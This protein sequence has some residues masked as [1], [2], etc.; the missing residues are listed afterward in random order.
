MENTLFICHRINK[1][2]ELSNVKIDQG[3]ELDLRDNDK[4][5][6][7]SHDPFNTG[8]DFEQIL[9][10]YNKNLII[11]N[12]KSERIEYKILELLQKYN[13]Q[14]YFFLDSSFPMIYQLNKIGEKNIAV[15]FSEFESIESVEAVKDMVKWVWVDCF[16]HFPLTREIYN[17]IKK[18]NLKICLVSPELQG[19]NIEMIYE[20]KKIIKE[21]NFHIDAICTK[22]YS[23]ELWKVH[24]P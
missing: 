23:V 13:I 1:S 4:S 2:E 24:T 11:L 6:F 17:K 21:N 16:T 5:I 19:H 8:E 18:C 7:L 15:R 22:H 3:I 9:K 20:F 10:K 14:E 12:I